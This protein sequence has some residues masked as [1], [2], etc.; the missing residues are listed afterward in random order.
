MKIHVELSKEIIRQKLYKPFSFWI[1]TRYLF[2]TGKFT[3]SFTNM[4]TMGQL[5]NR[6]ERTVRKYLAMA[7]SLHWIRPADSVGCYYFTS[8]QRLLYDFSIE[9]ASCFNF[10]VEDLPLMKEIFFSVNIEHLVKWRRHH[11]G[12]GTH[13]A[14]F[15]TL[16]QSFNK[17]DSLSV[18]ALEPHYT[19]DMLSVRY[20]QKMFNISASTIQNRK[21]KA[22]NCSLLNYAHNQIKIDCSDNRIVT[23]LRTFHQLGSRIV[24]KDG[25]YF[26]NLSDS[27]K[28][29]RP[30]KFFSSPIRCSK[31]DFLRNTRVRE[32]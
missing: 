7:K 8:Y 1:A 11:H 5:M 17:R 24:Y 18:D 28:F 26:L 12:K 13:G 27:F 3:P 4:N 2:P 14:R 19:P 23:G 10:N 20:L 15:Y 31:K 6:K 21:M 32:K 25:Q 16:R 29:E 22:S 30:T 9:S